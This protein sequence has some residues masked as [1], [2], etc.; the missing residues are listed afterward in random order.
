[1]DTLF[2]K[3]FTKNETLSGYF[4]NKPNLTNLE[5]ARQSNWPIPICHLV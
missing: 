1:M 3:H 4:E 2:L 5:K